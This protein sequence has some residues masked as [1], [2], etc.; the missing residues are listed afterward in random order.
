VAGMKFGK[1]VSE[2]GRQFGYADPI[3]RKGK[4]S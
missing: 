1:L 4:V 2:A 3:G